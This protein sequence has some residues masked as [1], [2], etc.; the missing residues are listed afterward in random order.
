MSQDFMSQ[1]LDLTAYS[2]AQRE[3]L[4]FIDCCLHYFGQVARADLLQT[5]QTGLASGTRDL[6]LYRELAPNNLTLRHD[7]KLYYRTAAFAPLF[8]HDPQLILDQLSKHA[9]Q[10]L[11]MGPSLSGICLDAVPTIMP[12]EQLLAP[13][14]LAISQRQAI[15]CDYVSLSSGQQSRELVPHT[16]VNNGRRWHIRAFDRRSQSFRDFVLTRFTRIQPLDQAVT[17]CEQQAQDASWHHILPLTLMAHP[18]LPHPEAIALDYGMHQGRLNLEVREALL[19]YVMQQW[20][21]DCSADYQLNPAQYP[22][23]LADHQQL[24]AITNKA[25]LPGACL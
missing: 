10:G 21:V 1:T 13:L 22:L 12:A 3:R 25:L 24:V 19:G 18:K 5:F 6:A 15:S 2:H 7:T 14:L 9:W 11:T 16:L 4:R 23:A 20:L 17:D 8:K